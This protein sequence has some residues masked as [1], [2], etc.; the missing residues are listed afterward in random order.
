VKALLTCD[1]VKENENHTRNT[2]PCHNITNP[3]WNENFMFNLDLTYKR[4]LYSLII[5]QHHSL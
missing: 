5:Y 1:N 4:F 3:V 2:S